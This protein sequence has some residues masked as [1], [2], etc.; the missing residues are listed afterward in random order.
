[1]RLV[2]ENGEVNVCVHS[3]ARYGMRLDA[4][5]LRLGPVATGLKLKF[6]CGG[7]CVGGARGWWCEG[8]SRCDD[9]S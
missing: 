5:A 4:N 8:H 1:M 3:D 2:E 7:A 9:Q 6:R